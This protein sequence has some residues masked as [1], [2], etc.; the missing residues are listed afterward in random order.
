[1]N[2]S[3]EESIERLLQVAELL[4]VT[5]GSS[6]S[7]LGILLVIADGVGGGSG[8]EGSGFFFNELLDEKDVMIFLATRSLDGAIGDDGQ[9]PEHAEKNTQTTT[10][11]SLSQLRCRQL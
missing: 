6:N 9:N 3:K 10:C 1:M 11:K 5:S 8:S 4:L 2:I 7:F